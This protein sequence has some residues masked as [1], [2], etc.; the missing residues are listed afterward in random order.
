M[1]TSFRLPPLPPVQCHEPN[2][3]GARPVLLCIHPAADHVTLEF[4]ECPKDVEEHTPGR[5][6]RVDRLLVQEQVRVGG[7]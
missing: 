3:F 5:R 6:G 2:A 1:F 7:L 4:A